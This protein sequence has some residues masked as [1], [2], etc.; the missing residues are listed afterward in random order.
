MVIV[1]FFFYIHNL[2]FKIIRFDFSFQKEIF[3]LKIQN[4]KYSN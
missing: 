2:S 3:L 1:M 4:Y